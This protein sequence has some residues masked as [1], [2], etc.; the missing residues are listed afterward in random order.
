VQ[1]GGYSSL[2]IQNNKKADKKDIKIMAFI[3]DEQ[4]DLSIY[5]QLKTYHF[6]NIYQAFY[7]NS[8][9]AYV[10]EFFTPETN[11]AAIADLLKQHSIKIDM[12]TYKESIVL[13]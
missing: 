10:L 4:V 3:S 9:Y 6:L 13:T 5:Q 1:A 2:Q 11:A 7:Q 12:G 8:L